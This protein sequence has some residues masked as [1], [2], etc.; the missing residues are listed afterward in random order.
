MQQTVS[1]QKIYFCNLFINMNAHNKPI[2]QNELLGN[3]FRILRSIVKIIS[4]LINYFPALVC[5]QILFVS[6]TPFRGKKQRH[7]SHTK[8]KKLAL[9][10]YYLLWAKTGVISLLKRIHRSLC[11]LKDE[12]KKSRK[13]EGVAVEQI[14]SHTPGIDSGPSGHKDLEWE[15]CA[16]LYVFWQWAVK[17]SSFGHDKADLC[18]NATTTGC[19]N[20]AIREDGL[21][22]Q[23][24]EGEHI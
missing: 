11:R 10:H 20:N 17:Q 19:I 16:C 13:T 18:G 22:I 3:Y 23:M 5:K 7:K 21:Q 1:N 12:K 9:V 24:L 6:L 4:K 15:V 2:F 14:L 8:S